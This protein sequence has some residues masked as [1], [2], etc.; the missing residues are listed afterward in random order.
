MKSGL[1]LFSRMNIACQATSGDMNTFFEYENDYWPLSLAENNLMHFGKKSD[2]LNSLETL[3]TVDVKIY[4]GLL[5][6]MSQI[7]RRRQQISKHIWRL[8]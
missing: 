5:L 2:L 8:C 6:F 7:Q 1:H 3:P 4:G